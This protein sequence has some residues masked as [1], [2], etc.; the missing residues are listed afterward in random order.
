MKIG[1]VS[2][3]LT[4]HL[5]PMT[6]LARKLQSRGHEVVFLGI[7]DAESIVRGANLDFIPFGE[8]EYPVGATAKSYGHLAKLHGEEVLRYSCQEMHPRRCK[9]ALEQLPEKLAQAGVEALVIDTIHFFVEL[10]PMSM[11]MP[12][13]HI[14]N[15]LHMDR[16]GATPACFFSWPYENTPE[17]VSRNIEGLKRVGSF[18]GPVV[19][20]AKSW[21]EKNGLQID[22][23]SPTATLSKL[24]VITQTPRE[25]DFSGSPWPAQF[26][27][28]GPFHDGQG[29]APIPFPWEKLTGEPLIYASMGTLVNGLEHVY[30]TILEAAGKLSG[31]QIVVSVGNN[32]SLDDLGPIPSNAIVVPKAPQIELLRDAALCITHTGANTALE[33]LA[34]GVPMVAIPIGFDQPGVAARIAYHGVGEFVEVQ[35]LTVERLSALIRTVLNNPGYRGKAGYFQR[36]I[37]KTRGLDLAADVIERAFHKNQSVGSAGE[38]AESLRA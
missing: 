31:T 13:A 27:Y 34:H 22:W 37:A 14:W 11:G 19:A 20:V 12:Y 3:P 21:A 26:H 10:V 30:R 33:A 18:F 5:N 25:F 9:V 32:L 2:M 23:S 6:A 7:P 8:K 28:S 16:S 36:V 17:A 29:R 15:V 35:D 4:G 38:R 24:A 1:F